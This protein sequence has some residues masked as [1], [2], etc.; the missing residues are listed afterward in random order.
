MIPEKIKNS[1]QKLFGTKSYPNPNRKPINL[2]V[3]EDKSPEK[4]IGML[5]DDIPIWAWFDGMKARNEDGTMNINALY[6]L[7]KGRIDG[8]A[9]YRKEGDF[10]FKYDTYIFDN[11][12][13][14]HLKLQEVRAFKNSNIVELCNSDF[15]N[16][17]ELYYDVE[18]L[19]EEQYTFRH[20]LTEEFITEYLSHNLVLYVTDD[21]FLKKE[22]AN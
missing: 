10:L 18:G 21:H 19:T 8:F 9:M 3:I 16:A 2:P 14:F 7:E 17:R 15:K 4:I 12:S 20:D 13:K 6:A 5:R 22:E 11:D 1:F